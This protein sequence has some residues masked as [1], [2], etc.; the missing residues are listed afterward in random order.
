MKEQGVAPPKDRIGAAAK[1]FQRHLSR[2]FSAGMVSLLPLRSSA[3][4]EVECRT[5]GVWLAE[6]RAVALTTARQKVPSVPCDRPRK[7]VLMLGVHRDPQP[8]PANGNV[9]P[10]RRHLLAVVATSAAVVTAIATLA[11][12]VAQWIEVL[13]PHVR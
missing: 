11:R 3:P 6:R 2:S 9:G 8:E 12:A 4:K 1:A 13:A 7:D 5:S 10:R